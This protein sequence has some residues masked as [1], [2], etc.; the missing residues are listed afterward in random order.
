MPFRERCVTSLREDFVQ[1]ALAGKLP[2]RKLCRRFEISAPT[3]YRW[4]HRYQEQGRSGLANRSSRPRRSP[5]Q[6]RPPV[7]AAVL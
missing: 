7:E 5:R 1:L 2:F 3:G 6:T 4:L